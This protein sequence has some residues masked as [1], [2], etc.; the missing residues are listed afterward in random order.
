MTRSNERVGRRAVVV[1]AAL[2]G[3][4]FALAVQPRTSESKTMKREMKV[5]VE[6]T[7]TPARKLEMRLTNQSPG[8]ITVF[9]HSLPWS[10][11]YSA[12]VVAVEADAVG[13]VLDRSTPVDD[14]IAGALTIKPNETLTGQIDLDRRFPSLSH[15][16]KERDVIVF[17]SH[18]LQTTDGDPLPRTGGWTLLSKQR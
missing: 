16:L 1:V 17:W 8:P 14:P 18:Q 9:R 5:T 6:A 15:E 13:T 11:A 3:I 12:L 10:S 7:G 2:A 4:G